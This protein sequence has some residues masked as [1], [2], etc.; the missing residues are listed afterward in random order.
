MAQD[1]RLNS[2]I[3]RLREEK[4]A[5]ID[6]TSK[7]MERLGEQRRQTGEIRNG[8][9]V[10]AVQ[11]GARRVMWIA[12]AWL[13]LVSAVS[14]SAA[15][16]FRAEWNG[17]HITVEETANPS[18]A[19]QAEVTL[20]DR[21]DNALSESPTVWKMISL[22]EAQQGEQF[23]FAILRPLHGVV[24]LSKSF[25]VV[26]QENNYRLQSADEWWAGGVYDFC[27]WSRHDVIVR[28]NLDVAMTERLQNPQLTMSQAYVG[29][30]WENVKGSDRMLAMFLADGK[31]NLLLVSYKTDDNQVISLEL[32]GDATK[33]ELLGL[34]AAY[35]GE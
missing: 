3:R 32:T 26:P 30:A 22:E 34:A 17:I 27:T 31:D 7:V 6:V 13:L 2:F 14:V 28:Q 16:L 21:L 18:S 8:E 29:G 9:R 33:E 20:K 5:P 19:G 35:T 4:P 1:A 12:A 23:P 25:A 15:A 11:T 10:K 24:S